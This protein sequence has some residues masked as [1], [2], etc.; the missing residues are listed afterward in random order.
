MAATDWSNFSTDPFGTIGGAVQQ[1]P[2]LALGALG[3]GAEAIRGNQMP[4]GY[5]QLQQE[6]Q[7]LGGLG[8]QLTTQATQGVLPASAQG[9]IQQMMNAETARIRQNYAQQGLSGS[10]M[11]AQDLAA[12]NQRAQGMVWNE[13]QGFYKTGLT[14]SGMSADLYNQ[15]MQVNVQQDQD[16]IKSIASFAAALGGAS[17]G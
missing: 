16:F 4:K 9:G 3:I 10:S 8:S 5:N 12:V 14:A 2:G 13:L 1:N 17:N 6:A 11:E 7:Q 15:M